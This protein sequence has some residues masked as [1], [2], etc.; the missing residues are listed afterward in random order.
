MENNA[1]FQLKDGRI[2]RVKE[3]PKVCFLTVLCDAGKY[4]QRYDVTVFEPPPGLPLEEGLAVTINGELGM[5][6]PKDGVGPW[7]LQLIARRIEKGDEAKAPQPQGTARP[8]HT[9]MPATDYGD[10]DF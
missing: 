3:L 2:I 6:K 7:Q 8:K 5:R 4:P 1:R 10:V 9:T